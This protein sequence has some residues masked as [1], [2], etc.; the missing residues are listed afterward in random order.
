[1]KKF[2][3]LVGWVLACFVLIALL[4]S[5]N[6]SYA[7]CNSGVNVNQLQSQLTANQAL[8]LQQAAIAQAQ[9]SAQVVGQPVS[10]IQPSFGNL[11]NLGTCT[12]CQNQAG[13][14]LVFTPQPQNATP[15]AP[16]VQNRPASNLPE[17][18]VVVP[19]KPP[20]PRRG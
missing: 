17:R 1:M 20:V 13:P 8:A 16:A 5:A 2:R 15:L 19:S 9:R 7:Q 3:R 14:R 12:S 18:Y 4:L 6:V 11:A 10:A